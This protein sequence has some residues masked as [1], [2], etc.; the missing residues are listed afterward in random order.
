MESKVETLSQDMLMIWLAICRGCAI[1]EVGTIAAA[2]AGVG[3]GTGALTAI[4]SVP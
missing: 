3:I 2:D 4:E 1:P